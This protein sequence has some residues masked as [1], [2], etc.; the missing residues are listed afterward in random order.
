MHKIILIL[1]FSQLLLFSSKIDLTDK[2]LDIKVDSNIQKTKEDYQ[3]EN[4]YEKDPNLQ[5]QDVKKDSDDKVK[6]DGD[7]GINKNNLEKPIDKVKVNMG[8]KF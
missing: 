8:T 7:V 2:S 3:K 6:I 1:I 5:L 4:S